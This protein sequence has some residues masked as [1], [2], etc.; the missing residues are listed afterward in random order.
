MVHKLQALLAELQHGKI[1]EVTLQVTLHW[2][3]LA[4]LRQLRLLLFVTK[5][6]KI[7]F[8]S[9]LAPLGGDFNFARSGW[10]G[11]V[12][13][14]KM[15]QKL[16]VVFSQAWNS[17]ILIQWIGWRENWQ[18]KPHN[19]NGKNHGFPVKIFSLKPIH[20]SDAFSSVSLW[21]LSFCHCQPRSN[22]T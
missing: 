8:K 17:K 4:G 7:F 5:L 13:S 10:H 9:I 3:Q 2:G 6:S 22:G 20:W 15:P 14:K 19:L 16:W 1:W 11:S 18:E 21:K 12:M